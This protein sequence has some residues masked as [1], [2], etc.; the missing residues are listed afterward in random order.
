MLS[1]KI[2]N[3]TINNSNWKLKLFQNFFKF[4]G[5]ACG[6]TL[7]V[8][9]VILLIGTITLPNSSLILKKKIQLEMISIYKITILSCFLIVAGFF[10]MLAEVRTI[11]PESLSLLF[12]F[13]N[14]GLIYLFTGTLTWVVVGSLRNGL[15]T[16]AFLISL[17]FIIYVV[18]YGF[19]NRKTGMS[20]EDW[21]KIAKNPAFY[22]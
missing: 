22:V 6:F 3:T 17:A 13:S 5:F 21:S 4:T 18:V 16:L 11:L 7:C 1:K 10:A 19:W 20:E 9:G 12:C 14:R 8:V 2:N 15:T